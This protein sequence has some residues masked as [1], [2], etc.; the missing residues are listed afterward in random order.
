[1]EAENTQRIIL[2]P[3]RM[4]Q[5]YFIHVE[6]K[7]ASKRTLRFIQKIEETDN[8]QALNTKREYF[9]KEKLL[10]NKIPGISVR[11]VPVHTSTCIACEENKG[12]PP[13]DK[14]IHLRLTIEVKETVPEPTQKIQPENKV[15]PIMQSILMIK[16]QRNAWRQRAI[17]IINYLK[18]NLIQTTEGHCLRYEEKYLIDHLLLHG[19][20]HFEIKSGL[21]KYMRKKN[22]PLP[23]NFP[24]Q[25]LLDLLWDILV[26]E[27]QYDL[28]NKSIIICEPQLESVIG[29][30]YLHTSQLRDLLAQHIEIYPGKTQKKL[31][32]NIPAKIPQKPPKPKEKEKNKIF[33]NPKASFNM[34]ES[35]K[36]MLISGLQE[37]DRSFWENVEIFSYE[38]VRD[39]WGLYISQ[40]P[41]LLDYK[42]PQIMNISTHPLKEIFKK[43]FLFEKQVERLARR[44]L[45]H[46]PFIECVD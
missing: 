3:S 13:K 4:L 1:M 11:Q 22:H 30:K 34:S 26:E 10:L 24:L 37:K 17:P 2:A 45:I 36:V 23:V 38:Q 9:L 33:S 29:V 6:P 20:Y 14:H 31:G 46:I 35:C 15:N 12:L 19:F 8:W 41:K 28:T 16:G 43:D 5:T 21:R 7:E 25:M 39:I 32:Y 27:K 18:E 40:N 42:N 44:E